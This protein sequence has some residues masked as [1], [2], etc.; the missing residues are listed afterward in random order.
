VRASWAP[1]A[2][3]TQALPTALAAVLLARGCYG[4]RG[5]PSELKPDFDYMRRDF[6]LRFPILDGTFGERLRSS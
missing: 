2:L 5:T 1:R 4:I 3:L 6:L